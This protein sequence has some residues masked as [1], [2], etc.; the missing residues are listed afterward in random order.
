MA[1]HLA[2]A[3]KQVLLFTGY[4]PPLSRPTLVVDKTPNPTPGLVDQALACVRPDLLVIERWERMH[5]DQA[6]GASRTSELE[7]IG[8]AL[9]QTVLRHKLPCVVT[10]SL[11]QDMDLNRPLMRWAG[12]DSPAGIMTEFCSPLLVLRRSSPAEV[13]VRL[14]LHTTMTD[15]TVRAVAWRG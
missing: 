8:Q 11:P 3:G 2:A 5:P 6:D 14:E 12:H 15:S 9:K 13:L 1:V 4:P 10:T 7:N